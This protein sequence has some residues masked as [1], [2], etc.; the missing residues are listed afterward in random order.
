MAVSAKE[1]QQEVE[2]W[3]DEVVIGLDLCPFAGHPRQQGLVHFCISHAKSIEALML[4]VVEQAHHLLN[5]STQDVE[6]T[7]IVIPNMLSHFDD[8]LDS[9]YLAEQVLKSQGCEGILQIASFHP[10]YRFE[11][12]AP[13]DIENLTNRSPYPVFHLLRETSVTRAT[14]FFGDTTTIPERNKKTL[15]DLS[16][17]KLKQLFK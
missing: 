2:N 8:Y 1:I 7:L 3:L 10:E 17:K 6:T 14:D 12:S 15:K 13:D 4:C 16:A 9:L 5:S 11:G